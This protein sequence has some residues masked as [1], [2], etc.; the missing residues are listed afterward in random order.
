M[1]D[2]N[3]CRREE[4]SGS[5]KLTLAVE[6]ITVIQKSKANFEVT[7]IMVIVFEFINSIIPC[8]IK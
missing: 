7:Q 6:A 3:L 1:L 2:K 5:S 8:F 4:T